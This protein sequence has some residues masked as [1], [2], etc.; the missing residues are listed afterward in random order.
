MRRPIVAGRT[1]AGES[2]EVATLS[3]PPLSHCTVCGVRCAVC[4]GQDDGL[5]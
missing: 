2:F 1:V 3:S 5:E 4:G